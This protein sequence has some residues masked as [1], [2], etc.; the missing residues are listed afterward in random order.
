MELYSKEPKFFMSCKLIETRK[1]EQLVN[2][3]EIHSGCC[4]EAA[5]EVSKKGYKKYGLELIGSAIK[6]DL[7]ECMKYLKLGAEVLTNALYID[8]GDTETWVL[9]GTIYM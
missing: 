1:I 2:V 4:P 8:P 9:L 5:R 6:S 7:K 3:K